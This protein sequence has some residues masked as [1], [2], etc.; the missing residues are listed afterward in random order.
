MSHLGESIGDFWDMLFHF[1][2]RYKKEKSFF[3]WTLLHLNVMP[4][5][6]A[7]ILWPQGEL[8]WVSSPPLKMADWKEEKDLSPCMSEAAP[9]KQ[10][11]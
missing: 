6:A 7:A 5:I 10:N 11:Q 1:Y 4:G 2:K 3:F 8:A 9:E